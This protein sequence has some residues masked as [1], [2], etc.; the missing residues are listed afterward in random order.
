M[1]RTVCDVAW[2]MVIRTRSRL[3]NWGTPQFRSN[4]LLAL[5]NFGER[6]RR[7]LPESPNAFLLHAIGIRR[8]SIRGRAR[9]CHE[10]CIPA[11]L[12]TENGGT[13]E[14]SMFKVF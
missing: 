3:W 5:K 13:D 12:P 6:L 8:S 4:N 9:S 2:L 14:G 7:S 1:C 11:G 10:W